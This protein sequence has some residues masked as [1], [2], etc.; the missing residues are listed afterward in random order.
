L[1]RHLGLRL[2]RHP[3]AASMT[4]LESEQARDHSLAAVALREG[5]RY[6]S[7]RRPSWQLLALSLDALA[8]SAVAIVV[9]SGSA[10]GAWVLLFGVLALALFFTKGMYKTPIEL[11]MLDE[12]RLVV[13][14]TAIA[15]VTTIAVAAAAGDPDPALGVLAALLLATACVVAGRTSLIAF[16]R[17]A[18]KHREAGQRTLIVGAGNVGRLVAKRL[19]EHP[20][21]GLKPVGFLDKEPLDTGESAELPVLG[22]SWDLEQVAAERQVDHVVVAFSTAPDE[23]LLGLLKR[24]ERLGIGTS[25]VP[26]L[27]EKSTEHA[28]VVPLGGLPLITRDVPSP[29]SWRFAIK[30]GVDRT[31]AAVALVMLSPV[32]AALTVGVLIESG[33]PIFYG[34][35]RIGRDGR[36]F[37]MWKFR[38]MLPMPPEE[39][40]NLVIDS[41]TG[42]GGVNGTDR[43]TRIGKFMRRTS[44]DELPQLFNVLKGEMSLV[45]PRP[46]RSEYVEFYEKTVPRYVDRHRVKSGITGW[47]QVNGLRGE[48][49][50][51]DRAEW[52][53]Y[54]IENWSLWLDFKIVLLTFAAVFRLSD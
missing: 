13:P 41:E 50:L 29:K 30:H 28:A 32:L 21:I 35:E 51:A 46:E 43:R 34:A 38:S 8:L 12:I 23:V 22:A 39:R 45:G 7:Y 53:N 31:I 16:E 20:E 10:A 27:Y 4:T 14:T 44:L 25:V 11:R 42:T 47:A 48:T 52:D 19:V 9:A 15:A 2:E 18:R 17:H 3:A 5:L 36:R 49:S 33:R 26:R 6:T 40:L 24:C 37:P 1:A 54:Y